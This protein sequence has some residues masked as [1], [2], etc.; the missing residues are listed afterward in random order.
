MR[1]FHQ[2]YQSP[3]TSRALD[4]TEFMLRMSTITF[5]FT[6]VVA[7]GAADFGA[8]AKTLCLG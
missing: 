5:D 3:I 4:R 1:V 6:S 7:V 2:A 8:Q